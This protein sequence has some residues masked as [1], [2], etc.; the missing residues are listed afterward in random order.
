MFDS[1]MF[2][3]SNL[4]LEFPKH[5]IIMIKKLSDITSLNLAIHSNY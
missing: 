4:A 3:Q 2:A 1:D 5:E